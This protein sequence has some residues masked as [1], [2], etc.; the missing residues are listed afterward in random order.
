MGIASYCAQE[1]AH[2]PIGPRNVTKKGLGKFGGI[3]G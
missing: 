2:G 1:N 3:K